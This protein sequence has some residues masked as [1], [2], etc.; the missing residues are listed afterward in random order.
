MAM[1]YHNLIILP[2]DS[3]S[4]A[5]RILKELIYERA[6]VL[7]VVVGRGA[8]DR[9]LCEVASQVVGGE[10]SWSQVLWVRKPEVFW[11]VMADAVGAGALPQAP[12]DVRALCLNLSDK[13]QKVYLRSEPVP[14][15][16]EIL[17]VTTEAYA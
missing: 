14:D 17:T 3:E 5:T 6:I 10:G 9:K 2:T 1:D 11:N 12:V 4:E 8:E 13:V 16:L 7:F 15:A